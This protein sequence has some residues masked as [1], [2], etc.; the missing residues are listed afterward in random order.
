MRRL[1]L[2]LLGLACLC[3]PATWSAPD[4]PAL[5]I[6]MA[7]GS[8]PP[9][10]GREQVAQ[11]FKHKKRY[12]DDG[13][14]IQAVN[15]PASHPLRRSFTQQIYGRNPEELE[16]YWRDQYFHG[17]LPPFVLGSE[18]AVIR[19]VAST[20]GAIGYISAC[21]VDH[22]VSVLFRLDGNSNCTH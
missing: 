21:N 4:E 15:L 9:R 12:W 8:A 11:I 7:S 14:R 10:L 17:V 1:V 18:E 22:R 5:A 16:D 3:P 20:P 19:L 6:V 13:S 2:L